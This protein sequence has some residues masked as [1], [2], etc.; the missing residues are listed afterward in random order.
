VQV[1]RLV[2]HCR[3]LDG[4]ELIVIENPDKSVA[5]KGSFELNQIA[6]N[7]LHLA[8]TQMH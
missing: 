1:D 3:E 6:A 2:R 7:A 5:D 4:T 8:L